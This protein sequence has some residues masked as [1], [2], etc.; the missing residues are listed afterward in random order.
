LVSGGSQS[1]QPERVEQKTKLMV[2]LL[3][4]AQTNGFISHAVAQK[5]KEFRKLS[6]L[7]ETMNLI[8]L[9]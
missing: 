6:V 8:I 2:E 9:Y 5:V 7:K 3:N 4:L 1:F